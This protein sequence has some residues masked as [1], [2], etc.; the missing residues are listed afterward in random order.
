MNQA[1]Y[2]HMNNKRKRKKNK[3]FK[4]KNYDCQVGKW[5]VYFKYTQ[6]IIGKY[7]KNMQ[8]GKDITSISGVGILSIH[9]QNNRVGPWS[10]AT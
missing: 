6:L 7:A 3:K 2:T 5:G 1:L 8:Q 10:H 9:L 4:K